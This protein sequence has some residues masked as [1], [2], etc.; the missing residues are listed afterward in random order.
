LWN[1]ILKEV[2]FPPWVVA[3]VEE[4]REEEEEEEEKEGEEKEEK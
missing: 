3:P 4:E 2:T 1:E